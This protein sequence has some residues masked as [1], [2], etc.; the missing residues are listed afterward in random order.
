MQR[1]TIGSPR[2]FP[3]YANLAM[4]VAKRTVGGDAVK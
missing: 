4:L 3:R 2:A 1:F